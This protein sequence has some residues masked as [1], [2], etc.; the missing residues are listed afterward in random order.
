MLGN[1]YITVSD[2]FSNEID[3]EL[4]N[5]AIVDS[6]MEEIR[7]NHKYSFLL[8]LSKKKYT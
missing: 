6:H 2:L 5:H 1:K 3:V 7:H 8:H 4:I